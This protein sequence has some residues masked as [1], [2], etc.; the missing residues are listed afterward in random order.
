MSP[1]PIEW[2]GAFVLE[3]SL[4]S[5]NYCGTFGDYQVKQ[6]TG[7][8]CTRTVKVTRSLLNVVIRDSEFMSL[9]FDLKSQK[10]RMFT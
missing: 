2:C 1:A 5:I 6:I 10:T 7:S 4:D 3:S 8:S 9:V